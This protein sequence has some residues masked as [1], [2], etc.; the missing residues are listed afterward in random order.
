MHYLNQF[1][2]FFPDK[3]FIDK[4]IMRTI[5]RNSFGHVKPLKIHGQTEGNGVH[6]ISN[7]TPNNIQIESPLETL[8][9]SLAACELATLKAVSRN[10][11]LKIGN[12]KFTRV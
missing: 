4:M 11:K 2:N 3:K 10:S 6:F 8:I 1:V 9:A 7:I 12:V 5:L